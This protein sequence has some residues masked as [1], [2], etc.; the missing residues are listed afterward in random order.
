[1]I[2]FF[3]KSIVFTLIFLIIT[4]FLGRFLLSNEN[5]TLDGFYY[6]KENS[7]DVLFF[8]SSHMYTGVNPNVIWKNTGITSYNLG[9]PEQQIWTTYSYIKE[10]LKYQNPK[11]IFVDVYTVTYDTDGYMPIENNNINLDTMRMSKNKLEAINN[12]V[13]PSDRPYFIFDLL[14]HKSNWKNI[15][16]DNFTTNFTNDVHTNKGYWEWFE[17][18]ENSE[19]DGNL[20]DKIGILPEKTE[21]YLNKIIDLCKVNDIP[22]VFIKTPVAISNNHQEKYN[23]VAEI[24]KENDIDFINFNSMYDELGIDFK[25]DFIDEGKHL[26]FMGAHKVS[27]YL[28]DYISDNFKITD[29]RGKDGY[30]DWEYSSNV[31]YAKEEN[32]YLSQEKDINKYQDMIDKDY[33]IV[34]I[35]HKGNDDENHV[36]IVNNREIAKEKSCDYTFSLSDKIGDIKI[37]LSFTGG[38]PSIKFNDNEHI[39]GDG[40]LSIVVYDK[41]LLKVADSKS[42]NI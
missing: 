34:A 3:E 33:Y 15:N 36:A 30:D 29:K 19:P 17:V 5:R 28:S 6:E 42:Y 13:K 2:K 27:Y 32:Y 9:Q 8:G 14:K 39:S 22:L 31:W 40:N 38:K 1:M 11:A 7:L 12:S 41:R 4:P 21:L 35:T 25:S 23:R 24:A 26:N 10:A 20:T 37:D 16:K 18:Y